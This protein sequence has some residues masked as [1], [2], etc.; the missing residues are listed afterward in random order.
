MGTQN[1]LKVQIFSFSTYILLIKQTDEG[2]CF[3]N[4]ELHLMKD[5]RVTQRNPA[6]GVETVPE[7]CDNHD[8]GKRIPK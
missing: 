5:G 6:V 8:G 1:E 7:G 3:L 4:S 2:R